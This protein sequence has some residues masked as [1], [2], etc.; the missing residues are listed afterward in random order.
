MSPNEPPTGAKSR[1]VTRACDYCHRRAIRCMR[2]GSAS[3][4][5]KCIQF[6]QLCTYARP[7]KKRG[8]KPRPDSMIP[9][10]SISNTTNTPTSKSEPQSRSQW[11]SPLI[12]SQAIVM[13][14]AEVYFEVVYPIFPLFHQ[15]TYLRRIARGEHTTDRH[16]FSATM[17]L[18]ALVSA[19][20]QDQALFNMSHDT[21]ELT[22]VP[23]ETFYGA[24]VQASTDVLTETSTQNL[25]LLRTCALLSLT[26]IQCGRIRD[27]QRFLG[28]YHTLVAM[29]RLHD[30]SNWPT[31]IGIVETEE[32]RRLVSSPHFHLL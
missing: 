5:L 18:C 26:A 8:V 20:V 19:R 27:M 22:K 2:D 1:R 28:R 3:R 21:E 14:L 13:S 10:T 30:E 23:C 4:C 25:D 24:A 7:T 6:D 15:P 29:D 32:R 9:P 11:K 17:A 16:L 31:G 12:A